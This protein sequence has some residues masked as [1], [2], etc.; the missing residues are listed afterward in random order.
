LYRKSKEGRGKTVASGSFDLKKQGV[1]HLVAAFGGAAAAAG[2]LP[3]PWIIGSMIAAALMACVWDFPPAPRVSRIFGQLVIGAALGLAV[4]HDAL[5]AIVTD[6]HLV[7]AAALCTVA[8][9]MVLALAQIRFGRADLPTAMFSSI[10]GGPVEMAQFAERY[11]GDPSRVA[12][13]QTLRIMAI[14]TCFPVLLAWSGH[15]AGRILSPAATGVDLWQLLALFGTAVVGAIL[16]A[17]CRLANPAFLGALLLV[18]ALAAAELVETSMPESLAVLG[19]ILL[20]VSMGSRFRRNLLVSG[21]RLLV[22]AAATTAVLLA[23][24]VLVAATIALATTLDFRTMVLANAPGS[25]PEM[26]MTAR[27]LDLDFPAVTAFH[28]ARHVIVMVTIPI[29]YAWAAERF[30][31][32]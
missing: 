3:L 12:L 9:S 4:T 25:M 17:L 27:A 32:G 28:V 23:G 6:L 11:G 1:L 5:V 24:C 21:W 10:P 29:L 7:V 20:G 30:G 16:A 8:I 26:A 15:G 31:K 19:Q 18:G 2:Q 14:V 22:Q 13:A